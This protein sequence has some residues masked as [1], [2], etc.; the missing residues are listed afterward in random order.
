MQ[1]CSVLALLSPVI[2]VLYLYVLY[3]V[4]QMFM[5]NKQKR[6]ATLENDPD[7]EPDEAL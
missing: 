6:K 5:A 7:F 3:K 4:Y 2:L 1:I